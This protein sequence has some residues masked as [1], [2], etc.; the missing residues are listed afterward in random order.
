MEERMERQR[1]EALAW[2]ESHPPQVPVSCT[3]CP[4]RCGADRTRGQGLCTG[5]SQIKA[6]RAMLHQWEEPCISGTRG[7]GA[8]FFSGCGL[9]CCFCQNY[10]ISTQGYGKE[11][12]CRRL[13]EILLELQDQGAHNINL[14]TAGH[15]LPWVRQVLTAIKPLLHIPVVYNCGGYES[16]E[17]LRQLEG[18]VD[19]YLPDLKFRDSALARR[20]CGREDYFSVA[21]QAILEM[22]RQTGPAQFGP[23]GLLKRGIIIR[24]LVL[25][26]GYKDSMAVMEW[27]ATHLPA[28]EI[29]VSVMSQFYPTQGCKNYRELCRRVSTFEYG[30]ILKRMEELGL[31]QGY[32][33]ER[34]SAAQEYTP[35]FSL[36]G[37]D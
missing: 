10:P 22:F 35:D 23:D 37:L 2:L 1:Q 17:G 12:S 26:G 19:I 14:V 21:S 16:L 30:R 24:H 25:P 27:I 28:Q 8:V 34:T 36:Q 29:L 18:L 32:T 3:L 13:G 7:S 11:I 5:G 4:R 20:Y 31:D 6:A 9:Q 33:Q 15:Y